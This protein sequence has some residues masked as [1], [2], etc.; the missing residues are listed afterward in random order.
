[1]MYTHSTHVLPL[2]RQLPEYLYYIVR[3]RE[4]F[5][6]IK[7]FEIVYSG[8]ELGPVYGSLGSI[9]GPP[10]LSSVGEL[11]KAQIRPQDRIQGSLNMRNLLSLNDLQVQ[12]WHETLLK[13]LLSAWESKR[14]FLLRYIGSERLILRLNHACCQ[15]GCH[16]LYRSVLYSWMTSDKVLFSGLRVVGLPEGE[17]LSD[18]IRDMGCTMYVTDPPI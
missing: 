1:M 13:K 8:K 2:L 10:I 14:N 15:G 18:V 4:A 9:N 17:V 16:R 11:M 5:A 3:K 7:S 12:E 6:S